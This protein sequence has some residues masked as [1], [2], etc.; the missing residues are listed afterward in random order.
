[1]GLQPQG[2]FHRGGAGQD[3]RAPSLHTR[4]QG[5]FGQ[6]KVKTHHRRAERFKHFRGFCT[7]RRPARHRRPCRQRQPGLTVQRRQRSKPHSLFRSIAQGWP[8]AKEIH[9]VRP[10]CL[11]TQHLQFG[12]QGVQAQCGGRQRAQPACRGYRQCQSAALRTRH[13]RL[14]DG[15]THAQNVLQSMLHARIL[16]AQASPSMRDNTKV[17]QHNGVGPVHLSNP[18][19]A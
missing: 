11:G 3:F 10:L 15:P 13:G 1:M 19:C 8:V 17:S 2:F 5:W 6:A 7:E 4:Q 12:T 16:A 9:V 14:N 18:S